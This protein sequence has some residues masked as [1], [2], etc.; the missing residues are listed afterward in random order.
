MSELSQWAADL[1]A[2]FESVESTAAAFLDQHVPGLLKVAAQ[3]DADPLVQAA[4][5]TVLPPEARTM[6]AQWIKDLEE[7]FPA[8]PPPAPAETA[9]VS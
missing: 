8:P 9:P 7:R 6:V 1:K 4:M 2:H 5:A 3:V